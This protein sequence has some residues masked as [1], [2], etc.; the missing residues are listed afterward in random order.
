M[1]VSQLPYLRTVT[2]IVNLAKA[3]ALAM[4]CTGAA[5]HGMPWQGIAWHREV[6]EV[7]KQLA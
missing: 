2:R 7:Q 1:G 5:R 4:A 3:L 6:Q